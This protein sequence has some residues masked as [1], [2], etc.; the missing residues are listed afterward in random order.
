MSE[1]SGAG[2][3]SL[4]GRLASAA[5]QADIAEALRRGIM[6]GE[7]APNQRLIEIDLCERFNARRGAVR[8]AF[9]QLEAE[10]LVE[11]LPNRG[12]RVR[13]I[14]V[15]EAVEI[16]E[17]RMVIEALCAAKAAERITDAEI[18]E[19]RRL[20]AE[21]IATSAANDLAA[22]SQ[23]N[24]TLHHRILEISGQKLALSTLDR[25]NA[26]NNHRRSRLAYTPGRI[27]PSAQEHVAIIDAIVARDPEAAERAMRVHMRIVIEWLVETE[28]EAASEIEP[29][30]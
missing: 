25:L 14:S 6:S 23:L 9:L 19:F 16:S 29:A 1:M 27:A 11:R 28:R 4:D 24:R 21:I 22:Y 8:A 10:G 13:A 3:L 5:G 15:T 2:H 30:Y 12:S 26:R 18:E 20:R 7:Y 17:L